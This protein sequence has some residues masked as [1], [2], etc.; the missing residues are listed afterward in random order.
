MSTPTHWAL[1]VLVASALAVA[2][3]GGGGDENRTDPLGAAE[4]GASPPTERTPVGDVVAVG[5][6]PEGIVADPGSG[7]VAVAVR[8]PNR[9]LLLDGATG[10]LRMTV[11]LPGH[12]RHLQLAGPGGPVLVAAEDSDTFL[13]VSLPDGEVEA[14]AAVGTYPHDATAVGTSVVVADEKGGTLSVVDDGRVEHRFEDVCQ[15][16]GMAGLSDGERFGVVDVGDFTLSLYDLAD[17]RRTGRVTAGEGPTHVVADGRDRLLVADTRGGVLLVY[18]TAPSL[19]LIEEV[20]LPGRPYGL[21][22]DA[23]RDRLWV[24]LTERNEVVA[25]DVAGKTVEVARL[26]TVPQPNTV[27]VD[28]STGRV[29]VA[30]RTEGVVQ[31]FDPAIDP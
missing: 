29:T 14:R 23:Q 6:Q 28:S 20:P 26:P 3:C 17:R 7:L 16:G 15:P 27:A 24:T 19:R 10:E 11:A 9:L 18:E 25:L 1:A 5:P 21:A 22:Y 13:E 8:E 31:L 2:A 30:S 4:P 12:A